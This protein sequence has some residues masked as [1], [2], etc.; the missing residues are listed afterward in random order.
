MLFLCEEHN[1]TWK[2]DLG[3][4]RR[5][6]KAVGEDKHGKGRKKLEGDGRLHVCR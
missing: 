5:I 6:G 2:C 3:M 1:E 4:R